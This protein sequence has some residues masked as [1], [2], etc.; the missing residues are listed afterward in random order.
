MANIVAHNEVTE[1][2]SKHRKLVALN[3][4]AQYFGYQCHRLCE[5]VAAKGPVTHSE[6][7]SLC[8]DPSVGRNTSLVSRASKYTIGC[9]EAQV[10]ALTE[11]E[12]GTCL[13]VLIDHGVIY[14]YQYPEDGSSP[15]KCMFDF[16]TNSILLWLHFPEYIAAVTEEA[17]NELGAGVGK[18]TGNILSIM[19]AA[20]CTYEAALKRHHEAKMGS[21][22]KSFKSA[23]DFLAGRGFIVKAD[24][25]STGSSTP[26]HVVHVGRI[27]LQLRHKMCLDYVN[28]AQI[29]RKNNGENVSS[30][31][32]VY[33]AFLMCAR[34]KQM[35]ACDHDGHFVRQNETIV[36]LHDVKKSLKNPAHIP[37][38]DQLTFSWGNDLI[39][40]CI[41]RLC[42][43]QPSA[44]LV[45][46][47]GAYQVNVGSIHTQIVH[48]MSESI[49][50]HRY[51]TE[52]ARILKLLVEKGH[53]EQNM[54]S[55]L[56][57]VPVH[58]ARQRL[59]DMLQDNVVALHEVSRPPNRAPSTTFYFWH[60]SHKML[61]VAAERFTLQCIFNVT[62]RKQHI[63]S[64]KNNILELAQTHGEKYVP[65]FDC[66][67]L[68]LGMTVRNLHKTGTI[69][70]ISD[71]ETKTKTAT[72]RWEEHGNTPTSV[73]IVKIATSK[74]LYVRITRRN[75]KLSDTDSA[76][77]FRIQMVLDRLDG[78][79]NKLQQTLLYFVDAKGKVRHPFVFKRSYDNM[80]A[81][82]EPAYKRK[83]GGAAAKR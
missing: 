80:I 53:L 78:S 34:K 81:S 22:V 32:E 83:R 20:G 25:Q 4:V 49:V 8:K 73:E 9:G 13:W 29:G 57:M 17:T 43:M 6:I 68:S 44:L 62:L 54:I 39:D 36:H 45:L 30:V 69:T 37:V 40:N 16:D 12:V 70:S 11:K 64:T 31:V 58:E 79:L 46:G 60:S 82:T 10:V 3:L 2:A 48:E 41:K 15:G 72:V 61:S 18:T 14:S 27:H 67:D 56:G 26:H 7:I 74:N 76:E 50:S 23:W 52:S 19:R 59:Y 77:L 38:S 21:K 47:N 5:I 55:E 65:I 63:V 35:Q 42:N 51:G 1:K 33:R 28:H 75:S 66:D 24:V 71:V